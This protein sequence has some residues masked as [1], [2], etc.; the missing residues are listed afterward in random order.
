MQ[1]IKYVV[2]STLFLS[3]GVFTSCNK[4]TPIDIMVVGVNEDGW[5]EISVLLENLNNCRR[6]SIHY[7]NFYTGTI[8]NKNVVVAEAPI[9]TSEASMVT[10]IG[11]EHFKPQYVITEGTSGGHHEDLHYYDIILGDDVL[12]IASYKGDPSRP[13]TME[14][15]HPTLH[16]D[17]FLLKRASEVTNSKGKVIPS[18]TIS[19]S[20]CWNTGKE[21]VNA[22]H[23]H[24]HED[25]EEMESYAVLDV[26]EYYKTPALAIRII[27]NNLTNDEDFDPAKEVGKQ[28]QLYTVDVIK[29]I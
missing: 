10:T 13:E 9:G 19:S 6:Q 21:Y 24:F 18:G 2:L 26:C 22:L 3:L 8:D 11:I 28:C 14:L 20:D 4:T 29:A 7:I 15:Q 23:N 25:C 16:S 12:D 1:K 5:N 27:S 17:A